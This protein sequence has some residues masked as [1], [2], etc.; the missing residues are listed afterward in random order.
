M[1]YDLMIRAC[2]WNSCSHCSSLCLWTI[3]LIPGQTPRSWIHWSFNVPCGYGTQFRNTCTNYTNFQTSQHHYQQFFCQLL[4]N[5]TR[6][7]IKDHQTSDMI[8]MIWNT[9]SVVPA[10]LLTLFCHDTQIERSSLKCGAV[11]N[12]GPYLEINLLCQGGMENIPKHWGFLEKVLAILLCSI[13][14]LNI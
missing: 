1:F 4:L 2:P 13:Q 8:V 3:A 10:A 12:R 7:E 5:N 11:R 6:V 9:Q 14:H